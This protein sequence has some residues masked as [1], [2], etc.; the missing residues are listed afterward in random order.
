MKR[1]FII[2]AALATFAAPAFAETIDLSPITT[3]LIQL[4]AVIATGVLTWAGVWL[5]AFLATKTGLAKSD[6]ADSIQQ[7]YN[8]AVGRSIAYAAKYAETHVTAL[9][10]S[11]TVNNGFVQL[12]AKY[13]T[14]YWPE[15]TKGIN[16][17]AIGEHI[18]ARLPAPAVPS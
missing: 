1:F 3:T 5:K 2:C 6:L 10:G 13:L 12:A 18:V 7:R 8:E 9:D 15:L 4:M 16:F 17:Q 11:I 14:E